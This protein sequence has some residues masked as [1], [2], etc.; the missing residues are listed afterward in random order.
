MY[1]LL[2]FDSN[3]KL[4]ALIILE[5]KNF[6]D[7]LSQ[8]CDQTMKYFNQCLFPFIVIQKVLNV[9]FFK[10]TTIRKIDIIRILVF[11][12]L[13]KNKHSKLI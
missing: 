2:I 1:N 3:I 11:Y 8:K 10:I 6:N 13:E 7:I 12:I 4:K 9:K 5:R